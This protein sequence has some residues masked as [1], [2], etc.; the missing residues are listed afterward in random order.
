MHGGCRYASGAKYEGSWKSNLKHG[1][2]VYYYPS[3]GRFEG[4][5]VDGKRS[6]VGVRLWPHGAAKV[7][8][9]PPS[10]HISYMHMYKMHSCWCRPEHLGHGNFLPIFKQLR[11]FEPLCRPQCSIRTRW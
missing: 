2:G 4:E 8:L 11:D 5:F 1:P 7:L 10:A 6:G 9:R 3:G